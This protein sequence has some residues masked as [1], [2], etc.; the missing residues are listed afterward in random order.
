[1]AIFPTPTQTSPKALRA[2]YTR[3]AASFPRYG[4]CGKC[5]KHPPL[6]GAEVKAGVELYLN[7]T[8]VP[9]CQVIG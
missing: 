5:I 1:V 4:S 6:S 7:S 2:S 9:S 8:S 3:G